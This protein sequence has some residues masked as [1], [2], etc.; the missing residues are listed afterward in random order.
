MRRKN[1][2]RNDVGSLSAYIT[3]AVLSSRLEIV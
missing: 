2:T 1:L 3:L